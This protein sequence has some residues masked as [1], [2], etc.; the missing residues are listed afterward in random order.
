ML[1]NFIESLISLIK[2][3]RFDDGK[4]E[5]IFYSESKFYRNFYIDLILNL[6]KKKSKKYSFNYFG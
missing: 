5:F 1:K 4:K 6:K 3:T 2:F